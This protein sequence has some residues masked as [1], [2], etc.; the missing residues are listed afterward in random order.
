MA[1]HMKQSLGKIGKGLKNVLDDILESNR[2]AAGNEPARRLPIHIAIVL[3]YLWGWVSGII[4]L[5]AEKYDKTIRFHAWQSVIVFGVSTIVNCLLFLMPPVPAG[6]IIYYVLSAIWI[7]IIVLTAYI[8]ILLI[9]RA[10]MKKPYTLPLLGGIAYRLTY[11]DRIQAARD[12]QLN[13]PSYDKSEALFT[14]IKFCTTCG[15]K[16]PEKAIFCP[17]C[18]EKQLLEVMAR[19]DR[20]GNI[21]GSEPAAATVIRKALT[22][23]VNAVTMIGEKRDPYTAG[24][25]RRVTELARSIAWQMNLSPSQI[26]GLTVAGQ[27]HDIG[28]IAVPSDILNK[29]GRLSEG[30]LIVIK[31]HPQIS[32]DILKTI[33]FPWPVAQIAYQHHE[34]IDGSGYPRGLKKE[35]IL[36]EAKILSVA[37][38]VEAMASHRPYRAA[39]GID[40]ALQEIS[41][42]RGILYDPDAVDACL[43]LFN[44]KGFEFE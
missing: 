25:Q 30:E 14:E 7:I 26:E 44:E 15:E 29:P 27:L 9:I 43:T 3:C 37:D 12:Q 32:Y 23:T 22:E 19:M 38:V 35:D 10:F 4:F 13:R 28:K 5:L 6:S 20:L 42:N 8:W 18:G 1:A 41:M 34:R 2:Q 39:L 33:E 11:G 24:H 31:S 16:L 21:L 36:I 17:S 40:K